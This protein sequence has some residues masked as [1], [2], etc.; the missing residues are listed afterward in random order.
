MAAKN[1][2]GKGAGKGQ[3]AN[4]ETKP[5]DSAGSPGSSAQGAGGEGTSAQAAGA[6]NPPPSGSAA[7]AVDV[8]GSPNVETN[9]T[10]AHIESQGQ[11]GEE[12]AG[13][14]A[15]RRISPKTV[16]GGPIGDMLL[17]TT[18]AA[19]NMVAPKLIMPCALY[20]VIGRAWDI[21]T[22]ESDFG[23]WAV[24]IGEFE[25]TRM[26]GHVVVGTECH[27][28][29]VAGDLLTGTLKKFIIEPEPQT[30]EEMERK[31]RRY[32][33]TGE[34]V[35]VAVV[36]GLRKSTRQGGQPYEFTV[37]SL[38][39]VKRSDALAALRAKAMKT[40]AALPNFK[41]PT[42]AAPKPAAAPALPAPE[43]K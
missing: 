31:T 42:L 43:S 30:P 21:R 40:M 2:A 11:P 16:M 22:G 8:T 17:P 34:V 19:G 38:V 4:D 6:S 33:T 37:Q 36:V 24:A 18:D 25:A 10:G 14:Q 9:D 20:T 35:D 28:P 32:K 1:D 13:A 39:P 7:A 27:V 12:Y 3:A 23:P 29:G 15:E 41:G 26:D 5:Q